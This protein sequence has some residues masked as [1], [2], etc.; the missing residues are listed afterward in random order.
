L[1]ANFIL[2][3]GGGFLKPVTKFKEKYGLKS[4]CV[5][6]LPLYKGIGNYLGMDLI[7]APGETGLF[8]TNFKEKISTALKAFNSGYD[9]VFLHLKGTDVYAEESGDFIDKAKYIEAADKYL[10]PLLS[11]EGVICVTGDHAT[12]CELKDHSTD[13]VPIMIVGGQSDG[14][15]K[16]S[17]K[18]CKNGSLGH[19]KGQEIMKI[20]LKEAKNG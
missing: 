12:P 3:R 9:F 5:A 7:T 18:A 1:P 14:V 10:K 17:E 20:L 13:P 16:F 11:F 2:T 4:A 19:I 15:G 8:D 6:G